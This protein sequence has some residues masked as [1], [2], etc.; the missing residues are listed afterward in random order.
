MQT[1]SV[2]YQKYRAS[3]RVRLWPMTS[4][5]KSKINFSGNES[6]GFG[7]CSSLETASRRWP[8]TYNNFSSLIVT[9]DAP[10]PRGKA[11]TSDNRCVHAEYRTERNENGQRRKKGEGRADRKRRKKT[12]GYSCN[13]IDEDSGLLSPSL[14]T[15]VSIFISNCL[16]GTN[17]EA[18][19]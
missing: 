18:F 7:C 6:R 10:S 13:G 12:I 17:Y 16:V 1:R 9:V 19:Y 4:P 8:E 3:S 14:K 2:T 11:E 5:N 15:F